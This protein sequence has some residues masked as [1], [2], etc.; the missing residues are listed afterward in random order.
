MTG[1]TANG[2]PSLYDSARSVGVPFAVEATPA[3]GYVDANGLRF[4]YLDWGRRDRPVVLMLH[5]F[6]QTCHMWDFAALSLSDRYRVLALDQRGHGDTDWAPDGDYSIGTQ[7]RDMVAVVAAL[8]LADFVL[9]GLS[10]GARNAVVYAAERPE[11]VRALV[12]VDWAPETRRAGAQNVMRFVEEPD[13]LDSVEEFVDR[14]RRYSHRRPAEQI[15]ASLLHNLKRLPSGKWTWKYDRVL[16][17]PERG[18]P[19][20]PG[21]TQRLWD[22]AEAVQSPTL[23]VRGA[24]SDIVAPETASQM[25]DRMRSARLVEV[26]NAGHRVPGDNPSGFQAAL[27]PFLEALA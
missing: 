2:I 1:P 18:R 16:R 26:P 25:R 20:E 6:A 14:V 10:M 23:V 4:H 5:G 27:D 15:R 9:V 11:Q 3:D 22:Y 19:A 17:S 8:G 7:Q 21:L 12:A 13:E 24:N